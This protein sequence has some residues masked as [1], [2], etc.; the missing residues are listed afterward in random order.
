MRAQHVLS[1]HLIRV[2]CLYCCVLEVA[3]DCQGGWNV[4][5]SY[6]RQKKYDRIRI[7]FF[8]IR[9]DPDPVLK[10]WSDPY[11][12]FFLQNVDPDPIF[13]IR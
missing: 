10:I 2:A 5:R 11:P 13:K 3:I 6:K 8:D 7:R 4:Y 9:Y 12:F 1:Y